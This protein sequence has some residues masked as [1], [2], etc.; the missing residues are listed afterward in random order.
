[1]RSTAGSPFGH[2]AIILGALA[3]AL[4][5]TVPIALGQEAAAGP[6]TN[7]VTYVGGKAGKANPKLSPIVIGAINTQGGQVLVGPGWTKQLSLSS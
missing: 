7:Y 3:L 4:A 5:V 6:V 2:L 1:M